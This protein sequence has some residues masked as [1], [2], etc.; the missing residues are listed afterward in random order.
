M[1]KEIKVVSFIAL[2]ML[3]TVLSAIGYVASSSS[4]PVLDT[5]MRHARDTIAFELDTNIVMYK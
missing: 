4:T 5:K 2:A 3:V 1:R